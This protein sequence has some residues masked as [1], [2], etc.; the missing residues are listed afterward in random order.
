MKVEGLSTVEA[1]A[2]ESRAHDWCL[3]HDRYTSV[4]LENACGPM[5]LRV[6]DHESAC[7]RAWA[8]VLP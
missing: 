3:L 2:R 6:Y 5:I 8:A 1:R 7:L 4:G